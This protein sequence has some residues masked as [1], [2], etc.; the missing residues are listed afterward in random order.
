M[1]IRKFFGCFSDSI[2]TLSKMTF[3]Q[4]KD[5]SLDVKP[6]EGSSLLLSGKLHKTVLGNGILDT[7]LL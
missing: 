7:V 6:L 2:Q 1:N 5:C 4:C 3:S